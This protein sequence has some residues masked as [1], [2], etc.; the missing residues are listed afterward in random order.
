MFWQNR[1]SY[2]PIYERRNLLEITSYLSKPC[3][4]KWGS[5][6][7]LS[8][9]KT[10]HRKIIVCNQCLAERNLLAM[11]MKNGLI[12]FPDYCQGCHLIPRAPMDVLR[13]QQHNTLTLLGR[14]SLPCKSSP[15]FLLCSRWSGKAK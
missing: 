7:I 4:I 11:K 12:S 13:R 14:C 2:P 5:R 10:Y 8:L 3:G 15:Q 9:K 6:R 1:I